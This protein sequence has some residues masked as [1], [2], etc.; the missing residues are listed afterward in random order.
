MSRRWFPLWLLMLTL[1]W[2]QASAYAHS[3]SHLKDRDTAK[4]AHVCE[5]CVA[6]AN[7]GSAAPSAPPVLHLPTATYDWFVAGVCPAPAPRPSAPR[8]RDPPASL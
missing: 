1:L 2:G 3:L 7:L 4:H 5:L 8:A 6:Q